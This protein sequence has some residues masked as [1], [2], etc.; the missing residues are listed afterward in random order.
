VRACGCVAFV[1]RTLERKGEALGERRE[2]ELACEAEQVERLS[3]LAG[4]ESTQRHVT[5]RTADQLVAE[6]EQ[7]CDFAFAVLTAALGLIDECR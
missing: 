4:V 5:F 7:L 6:R 3:A 2:H 1:E